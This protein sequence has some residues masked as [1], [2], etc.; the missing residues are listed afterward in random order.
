MISRQ[1]SAD[2]LHGRLRVAGDGIA[3]G[4]DAAAPRDA[5]ERRPRASWPIVVAGL[6]P[7]LGALPGISLGVRQIADAVAHPPATGIVGLGLVLGFWLALGSV[8]VVC[9]S[10]L[11]TGAALDLRDLRNRDGRRGR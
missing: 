5:R 10:V 9:V 3:A 1:R 8:F 6:V 2:A 4:G 11:L 7:A